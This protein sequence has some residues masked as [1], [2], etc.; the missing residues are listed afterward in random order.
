MATLCFFLKVNAQSQTSLHKPLKIGDAIPEAIWN[1]PLQ[2][3]NHPEGKKT[4]TL[5]DYRGKLIILDF[6]ATWCTACIRAMPNTHQIQENFKNKLV[7]LPIT[8]EPLNKSRSFLV[9]NQTIKNLSLFS[10]C[11]DTIMRQLFPYKS[12]PHYVWIG[13]NGSISAITKDNEVT[14]YNV[15]TFLENPTTINFAGDKQFDISQ[16]LLLSENIAEN[17]LGSYSIFI[18]GFQKTL[19]SQSVLRMKDNIVYG[20]CCTNTSLLSMYRFVAHNLFRQIGLVFNSNRDLVLDVDIPSRLDFNSKE[21]LEKSNL[22]SYDVILPKQDSKL[23]YPT[24]LQLIN[25]STEYDAHIETRIINGQEKTL[26]VIR[27]DSKVSAK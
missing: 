20:R 10:V 5:N 24:I 1:L 9:S 19:S 27:D 7:V 17:K 22:C 16:P 3:V 2:I 15:N 13:A 8:Y 6:W 25:S 21:P 23:L 12:I 11:A 26:F 18:K 4:I 14:N